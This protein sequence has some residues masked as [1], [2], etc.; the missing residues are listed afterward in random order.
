MSLRYM[1]IDNGGSEILKVTN[2]NIFLGKLITIDT[3]LDANK[4]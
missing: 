4:E 1:A 3:Y 2:K